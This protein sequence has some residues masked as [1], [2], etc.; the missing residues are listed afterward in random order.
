MS[1]HRNGDTHCTAREPDSRGRAPEADVVCEAVPEER[2]SRRSRAGLAATG[3]AAGSR[4]SACRVPSARHGASAGGPGRCLRVNERARRLQPSCAG[5]EA[6]K[7]SMRV[8]AAASDRPGR[9]GP[10]AKL[11]ARGK[12][13]GWGPWV[14]GCEPGRAGRCRGIGS[15]PA[16]PGRI[17]PPWAGEPRPRPSPEARVCLA[18]CAAPLCPCLVGWGE[19]GREWGGLGRARFPAQGG[20]VAR[21][22]DSECGRR[23]RQGAGRLASWIVGT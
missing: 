1:P 14:L 5:A 22:P 15:T 11:R 23:Q 7:R 21:S 2:L 20:P 12:G 9:A 13:P 10:E 3:R 17:A 18:G 16:R 6:W 8:L 19:A 4:G